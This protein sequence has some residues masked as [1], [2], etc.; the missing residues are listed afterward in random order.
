MTDRSTLLELAEQANALADQTLA[1]E[2][3]AVP[4]GNGDTLIKR[5]EPPVARLAE[6]VKLLASALIS[7]NQPEDQSQ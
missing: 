1:G 5:P 7:A 4:F 2:P 6:A 3:V